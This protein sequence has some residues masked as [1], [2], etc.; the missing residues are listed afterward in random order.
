MAASLP[1]PGTLGGGPVANLAEGIPPPPPPP[2]HTTAPWLPDSV[3]ILSTLPLSAP[4]GRRCCGSSSHTGAGRRARGGG[5]PRR[6]PRPSCGC[7]RAAALAQ[8]SQLD[9]QLKAVALQQLCHR[10]AAAVR[11]ARWRSSSWARWC[12][13]R[14]SSRSRRPRGSSGSRRPQ[15][16]RRRAEK[17][18]ARQ[19]QAASEQH[20]GVPRQG[21]GGQEQAR[22]GA[23]RADAAAARAPRVPR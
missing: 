7:S 6:R 5:E 23:A 11:R 13:C 22:G 1:A 8:Y 10:G 21:R 2:R 9:T 20:T 4:R 14:R 19:L 15:G 17:M 16:R 12:A 18:T 3:C